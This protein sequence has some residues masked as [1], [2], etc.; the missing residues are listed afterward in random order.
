VL[1]RNATHANTSKYISKTQ[2]ANDTV[3]ITAAV[4]PLP[5]KI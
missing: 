1:P 4:K 5:H 2:N 3:P